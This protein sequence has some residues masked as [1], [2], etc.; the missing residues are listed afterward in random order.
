MFRPIVL[1]M[2][3][4]LG[5]PSLCEAKEDKQIAIGSKNFTENRLL[6]EIMAQLIE[7]HTDIKVKRKPNLG[8][9]LVVFKALRSKHIDIYPEYTGTGWSIQLRKK[10]KVRDGLQAYSTVSFAFRR[11]FGLRWLSPFGFNNSYALAMSEKKANKL[12]IKSISD[13]LPH[14]KTLRVGVS[15]EF[16]KREDGYIGLSKFYGLKLSNIR[17]M[18]HGLAYEALRS[19]RIDVVDTW[20]TD[21]KL[22]KFKVRMLRDDRHF[23]PPYDAAPLVREDTLKKYPKLSPLLNKLAFRLPDKKMQ[24]L[25]A[26]VENG[27]SFAKVAQDFLRSEK[28]LGKGVKVIVD[29]GARKKGFLTFIVARR[30]ETMKLVGQH[31]Y[32][33]FVAVLLAILFSVPLG[34]FLTRYESL[35]SLI[36]N[37]VGVIQTIP[38]LALL[39]F[40]IP[41]PGLGLGARSAIMALFLYALLPIV[42]NT[43]TGIKSIDPNLIEAAR[44]IGLKDMQILWLV[45]LPLATRTIMAGIRTATVISIGVATLAAFVG[46]GG[47][48][49]PIVTGL[50]LNDTNLI[51]SGAVPAACLAIIGDALFGLLEKKLAPR[52]SS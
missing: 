1:L 29:N 28:L 46:A 15:H 48:G 22:S 10:T 4:L 33:T 38:S 20:T 42:R 25:N 16:L 9:T 50:Q 17:G 23:F 19:G 5:V 18:E 21:G 2:V 13:L 43:Y 32:L 8:G 31:L 14:A 39:A 12:N 52:G 7:A 40:M 6:A 51:L 26:K 37:V 36:M 27:G 44:A 47:L 45:E 30:A 24:Q 3:S 35:S 34:I 11:K 41:I 49:D